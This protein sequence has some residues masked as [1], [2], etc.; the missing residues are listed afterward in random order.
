M[1]PIHTSPTGPGPKEGR[2]ASTARCG[3]GTSQGKRSQF[4]WG[5]GPVQGGKLRVSQMV[6]SLRTDR[7]YAVL[8]HVSQGLAEER[9]ELPGKAQTGSF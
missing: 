4:A 5:K 9:G 1:T 3:G 7:D 8:T 6:T 2:Q